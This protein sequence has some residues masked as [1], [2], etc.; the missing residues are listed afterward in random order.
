M[1]HFDEARYGRTCLLVLNVCPFT[2]RHV[3]DDFFKKQGSPDIQDFLEK[4]KH[5]LYHIMAKKCCCRLI[6]SRVTPMYRSQWDLLYKR[7]LSPCRG[8]CSVG[9]DCPCK[10]DAIPGITTN[11]MDITLCC[12]VIKNICQGA[13]INMTHIDKIRDI[14]NKLIHA[15]S[16]TL[17]EQTYN[18]YWSDVKTA[19]LDLANMVSPTV[20]AD[21]VKMIQDLETRVM[22][23]YELEELKK[24][25]VNLQKVEEVIIV[26]L[27]SINTLSVLKVITCM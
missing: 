17:D 2:L 9:G 25:I 8:K 19:I 13:A 18:G 27:I 26:L 5:D 7:N 16:A 22:N 20:H 10:F 24:V 11:V 21:T 4:N 15:S 6:T 1:Y 12:L 3:I 14:R 23:R